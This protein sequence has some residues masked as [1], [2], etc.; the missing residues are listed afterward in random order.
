MTAHLYGLKTFYYSL[1]NKVG[2]KGQEESLEEEK[3]QD[4][5]FDNE[6][7]CDACKL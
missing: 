3:L 5:N 6:E 2:S 7:N 1:I 4:I